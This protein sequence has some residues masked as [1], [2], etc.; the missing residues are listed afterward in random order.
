MG[1]NL[2]RRQPSIST[3]R[4]A[5]AERPASHLARISAATL[6]VDGY[7]GFE[8]LAA[9]GRYPAGGLPGPM[10]GGSFMMCTKPRGSPIAGEAAAPD[11]R[12]LCHRELHPGAISRPASGRSRSTIPAPHRGPLKPW[13]ETELGR[14][15]DR[16]PNWPRRSVMPLARWSALW[17]LPRRWQGRDR[18]QSRGARPSAPS[19]LVAKTTFLPVPTRVLHAAHLIMSLIDRVDFCW[20]SSGGGATRTGAHSLGNECRVRSRSALPNDPG[21]RLCN[22]GLAGRAPSAM[23]RRMVVVLRARAVAA[24]LSVTSPRSARSPSR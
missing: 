6:Q 12:T 9:Q 24:S 3:A 18:Q 5:G 21:L 1:R 2:I 7:A 22:A 11:C 16:G 8:R 17:P 23:R 20:R 15:P 10:C 4:I 19:P 14:I 13:L